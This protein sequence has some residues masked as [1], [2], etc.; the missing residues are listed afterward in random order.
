M[1]LVLL[2]RDPMHRPMRE[3]AFAALSPRQLNDIS[4]AAGIEHARIDESHA[5]FR[6]FKV[7]KESEAV[8]DENARHTCQ[9]IL[10]RCVTNQVINL[11]K[12]DSGC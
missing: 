7:L 5:I 3:S 12:G 6:P 11:G 2:N 1:Q 4:V 9:A 8:A 10:P